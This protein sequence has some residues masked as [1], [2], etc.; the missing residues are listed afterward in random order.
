[1]REWMSAITPLIESGH[2]IGGDEVVAF[3]REFASYCGSK[4]GIGTASGSDSL[5]LALLALDIGPGDEVI[6]VP[7]TF[8]STADAIVHAGAT[9]VF[10]DINPTTF[11]M[12]PDQLKA[13]MGPRV[14]AIIPV[15]LYGHPAEL[16][17]ISEIA[18][19]WHVPIV[20]DAAHA[21][22]AT[23]RGKKC[24]SVGLMGCFSFYPSKNLGA[25]GDAGFITT[26]DEAIAN[27]L[28]LLRQYGEQPKNRHELIGYNS[29]L[30]AIQAAILRCKLRHLNAWNSARREMAHLYNEELA[31]SDTIEVPT[32]ADQASHVYHIYAINLSDRDSLQRHL[33]K[34]R[35]ETGVHYPLPIHL[36]PAYSRVHF[37]SMRLDTSEGFANRTLSLPMYP[38][39]SSEKVNTVCDS[40]RQWESNS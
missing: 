22:G 5:R 10:V 11:T 1:M 8:V 33:T 23:Y 4:F 39:L 18:E 12:N 29:R 26:D 32:E 34:E 17:S 36:Q 2:F 30:D 37:R 38:E 27:R 20:E 31:S 9:P 24:G 3:E 19:A 6:T 15:H 7:T 16:A 40:I 35:I 28:R 14:K 21:H 13:A 25:F